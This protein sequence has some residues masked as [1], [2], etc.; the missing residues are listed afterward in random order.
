VCNFNAPYQLLLLVAPLGILLAV[1][2]GLPL[3]LLLLLVVLR[4]LGLKAVL[5]LRL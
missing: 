3:D 2:A 1:F 4:D 5:L